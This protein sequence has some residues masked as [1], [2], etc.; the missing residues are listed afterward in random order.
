MEEDLTGAQDQDG[1]FQQLLSDADGYELTL[2]RWSTGDTEEGLQIVVRSPCV[3]NPADKPDT[4][5][6]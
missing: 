3:A 2:S 5:G 1:L 6:K 4:W